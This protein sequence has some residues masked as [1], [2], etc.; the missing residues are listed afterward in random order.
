MGSG[1]QI[2]YNIVIWSIYGENE[3]NQSN[4]RIIRRASGYF[5]P[6]TLGTVI[7]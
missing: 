6:N 3:I 7:Y 1:L 4:V 2:K 5:T